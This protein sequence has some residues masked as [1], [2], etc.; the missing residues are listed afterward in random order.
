MPSN[1]L[2]RYVMLSNGEWG[3]RVTGRVSGGQVVVV[4]KVSGERDVQQVGDLLFYE[5]EHGTSVCSIKRRQE[6]SNYVCDPHIEEIAYG[7]S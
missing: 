7:A 6:D 4:T 2:N 5:A 3:I 1:R